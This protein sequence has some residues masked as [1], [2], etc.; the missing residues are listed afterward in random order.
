MNRKEWYKQ[1]RLYRLK[2]LVYHSYGD[3]APTPVYE[4]VEH[5]PHKAIKD[6]VFYSD[7]SGYNM[8]EIFSKI[9]MVR[10]NYE[11]KHMVKYKETVR[12]CMRSNA[13]AARITHCGST[14]FNYFRGL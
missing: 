9:N 7:T 5:F 11:P 4:A 12:G 3:E 2:R 8:K 14:P 13:N 10:Q 6:S 1:R